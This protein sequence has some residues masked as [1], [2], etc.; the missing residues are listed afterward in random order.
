LQDWFNP[1]DELAKLERQGSRF[2]HS[3]WQQSI[4]VQFFP[5]ALSDADLAALRQRTAAADDIVDFA[6][7][8]LT[9]LGLLQWKYGGEI[10]L[11]EDGMTTFLTYP[12]VTRLYILTT[13]WMR[14]NWW[15]EMALVLQHVNRLRLRRSLGQIDLT[16]GALVQELTQARTIVIMLLRRLSPGKWYR[17]ADF[18]QLL[19]R[20]WPDYLHTG[21]T[22]STSPWWLEAAGSEEGSDYRLSPDKAGDWEAGYAPFVMACLEGPLAWLGVVALGYDRRRLAAFQLTDLGAYVLGLR[23]SYGEPDKEPAGPALTVHGDGTVIARTGHATT[24]AYDVLN[25]AARLQRTSAQQFVYRITATSAQYAFDQGWTGRAI[26]YE[27]EKHSGAPVPEPLRGHI[28]TWAES[29]GQVHLYNQVTLVEFADDFALQELLAS[30]SLAQH[31]VYQFSPRLV[32][33]KAD[34]VDTLRSE[35]VQLGHTPRI[36]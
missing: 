32:A 28:L 30:T 36:E 24:G 5:P 25:A 11:D 22:S 10:R 9:S 31:L 33:I 2:W 12:D 34:A 26:L 8:L 1:A 18:G 15:S 14:L 20:F 21:S 29:Y 6:F 16:Y 35:L 17:A 4:G 3:G 27:L 7:N 23:E 13:T 19:R